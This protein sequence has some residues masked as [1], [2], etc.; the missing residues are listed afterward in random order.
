MLTQVRKIGNS[1]GAI[2]PAYILKELNLTEGDQIDV[3]TEEGRIVM[4]PVTRKPKYTL[5]ELVAECD[6]NAPINADLAAWDQA[7][8]VGL[9]AQ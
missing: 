9:E 2:I 7:P 6:L 8:S 3:R 4:T 5:A 1:T